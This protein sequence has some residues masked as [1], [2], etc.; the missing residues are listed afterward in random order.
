MMPMAMLAGA[1]ADGWGRK[2]LLLVGFAILPIAGFVVESA[3]YSAAFLTLAAIA[4]LAFLVL[5]LLMPETG[6]ARTS[7]S[8]LIAV[9]ATPT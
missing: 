9:P 2:T 1:K 5:L 6:P 4:A 8:P 3:G 7:T